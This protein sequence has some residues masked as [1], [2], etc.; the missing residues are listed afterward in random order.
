[1]KTKFSKEKLD[2]FEQKL[3]V[4]K[5]ELEQMLSKIAQKNPGNPEDWEVTYPDIKEPISDKNELADSFEELESRKAIEDKLE[6]KLTWVKE[7]LEKIKK[8]TYGI[9]ETCGEMINE[10]RLEA[11]PCAKNCIKHAKNQK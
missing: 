8:G 1:M 9:C 11:F 10:D 5:A 6:E 4:R 7:A 2:H 3:K